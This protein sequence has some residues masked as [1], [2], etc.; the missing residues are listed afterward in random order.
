VRA[1][2]AAHAGAMSRAFARAGSYDRLAAL[3]P[4]RARVLDLACGDGSLLD[5]LGP[6]AIGIDVSRDELALARGRVA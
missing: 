4:P 1:F 5:R 3:V 2:H 6:R